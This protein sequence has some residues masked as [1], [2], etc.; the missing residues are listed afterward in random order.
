MKQQATAS[1]PGSPD[2]RLSLSLQAK[3][4]CKRHGTRSL[5]MLLLWSRGLPE[6]L[7]SHG[8]AARQSGPPKPV[9]LFR[10]LATTLALTRSIPVG[11]S[12]GGRFHARSSALRLTVGHAGN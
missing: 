9:F 12:G 8:A 10:D 11:F 3:V 5:R 2:T 1:S 7:E 4:H 6:K